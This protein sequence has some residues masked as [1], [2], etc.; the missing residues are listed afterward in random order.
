M[1]SELLLYAEGRLDSQ[2]SPFVTHA[3]ARAELNYASSERL[4]VEMNFSDSP[5]GAWVARPMLTRS[6]GESE[7]LIPVLMAG[8]E[9]HMEWLAAFEWMDCLCIRSGYRSEG[10]IPTLAE[11]TKLAVENFLAASSPVQQARTW[12]RS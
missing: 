4:A 7:H 1:G 6:G 3:A 8:D 9:A 12:A 5:T 11:E 2:S 10:R